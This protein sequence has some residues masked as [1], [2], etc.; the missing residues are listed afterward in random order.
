[1]ASAPE[2]GLVI[3]KWLCK[4]EKSFMDRRFCIKQLLF[5]PEACV[6]IK[7]SFFPANP[8]LLQARAAYGAA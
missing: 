8:P 3:A 6:Q 5:T 1:M 7:P 2:Q 4:Q